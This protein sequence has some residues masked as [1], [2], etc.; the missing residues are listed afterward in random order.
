MARALEAVRARLQDGS[1]WF[2]LAE[3]RAEAD[4]SLRIMNYRIERARPQQSSLEIE[5]IRIHIIDAVASIGRE[6]RVISGFDHREVEFSRLR[7]AAG[8]LLEELER[9]CQ[10]NYSLLLPTPE[11]GLDT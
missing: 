1:R 9:F 4:L 7:Y 3:S 6:S 10:E 2:R 8:E 5:T 11:S